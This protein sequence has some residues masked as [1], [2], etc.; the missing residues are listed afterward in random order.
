MKNANMEVYVDALG[1]IMLGY[2][3][4]K[5]TFVTILQNGS[6]QS[7]T[8]ASDKASVTQKDVVTISIP[9]AALINT[10]R[11]I[12]NNLESNKDELILSQEKT[13]VLFESLLAMNKQ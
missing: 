6:E 1:G 8:M 13:A 3:V 10:C 5:V 2:P 12:L 7:E 11:T 9:T 4:S